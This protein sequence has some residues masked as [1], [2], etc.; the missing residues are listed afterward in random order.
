[1]NLSVYFSVLLGE[2][3]VLVLGIGLGLCAGAPI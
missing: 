1:M 3:A 2:T